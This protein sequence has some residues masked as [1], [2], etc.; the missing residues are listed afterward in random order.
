M[1][2][3]R[4]STG[5]GIGIVTNLND[6][7]QQ[8]RI[9][10]EFPWLGDSV[11]SHWCRLSTQ[12]GGFSRGNF[13][14]PEVGDEV[15]VM[16][17][18]GDITQP[19][20]VGCLWNGSDAPPGPG[21]GD[22]KNDFK[23]FESRSDHQMIFNDGDDGGY[24]EFHDCKKKLH[25]KIDVPGQ[26]IHSLAD[27]GEISINAPNGLVRFEC[28]DF[29]VH[30]TETT[31]VNVANSHG[32]NVTGS[33]ST[34]VK[35]QNL[36]QKAGKSLSV[37]TPNMSMSASSAVETS[38]GGTNIEIGSTNAE[39]KPTLAVEQSG[40][41]TRKIGSATFKITDVGTDLAGGDLGAGRSGPLTL[42]AGSLG[43]QLKEAFVTKVGGSSDIKFGNITMKGGTVAMAKDGGDGQQIGKAQMVQFEGGLVNLNPAMFTGPVTKMADLMLGFDVHSA[44]PMPFAFVLPIILD[45]KETVLVN[46]FTMAGAGTAAVGVHI[47]VVW[48]PPPSPPFFVPVPMPTRQI[49]AAAVMAMFMPMVMSVGMMGVS[50]IQQAAQGGN[51]TGILTGMD[52]QQ[53]RVRLMPYTESVGAFLATLVGLLPFPAASGS[54]TLAAPS[55]LGQ[56][57][58]MGF[59]MPMPFAN[60]CSEIPIIPNAT[61]I[62][63]STVMAGASM[64]QVAAQMAMQVAA[65]GLTRAMARTRIMRRIADPVDVMSGARVDEDVDVELPG[66]MPLKLVRN[67]LSTGVSIKDGGVLGYGN[68]LTFERRLTL[69]TPDGAPRTWTYHTDELRSIPLPCPMD[70]GEW[71]FIKAEQLEICRADDRL[72]D[73]RDEHGIT[74]RFHRWDDRACRLESWF[75]R[76]G[77]TCTVHYDDPD[78]TRATA[79]TDSTGRRLRLD[80]A[81]FG[82]GA[83]QTHRLTDIWFEDQSGDWKPHRLRMYRYDDAGQL[84]ATAGADDHLTRYVY[85]EHGRVTRRHEPNGYIWHWAYDRMD[86]VTHA[87]GEDLRYYYEFDYQPGASMTI[88]K[89][90]TGRKTL[91]GYDE[92]SVIN[93]VIDGEGVLRDAK[94][95]DNCLVE[96]KTGEELVTTHSYDDRGR[97]V[98]T[99]KPN[100]G[101]TTRVYD[102]THGQVI[103]EVSPMGAET[104]TTL[105]RQ[106]NPIR[107]KHPDGGE[108]MRRF[109]AQGRVVAELRPDQSEHLFTYDDAGN[110][111]E[112]SHDGVVQ[113]HIYDPLGRRRMTDAGGGQ[114]TRFEYDRAGR[115]TAV[116]YPDGT[117]E[118][119]VYDAEG[120]CI[121]HTA[122]TGETWRYTY[123]GAGRKVKTVTPEGQVHT[124][125]FGMNDM[126]SGHSDGANQGFRY[127]Y[128]AADR[129]STHETTDGVSERY[130]YDRHGQLVRI[131]HSDGSFVRITPA[132]H[133]GPSELT[134]RDGTRQTRVYNEDEFI[135][136]ALEYAPGA[137]RRHI[138]HPDK[139]VSGETRVVFK[140]HPDG[141]VLEEIGPHGR[142]RYT[143]GAQH[144][145]TRYNVDGV[146]LKIQR[147][148]KGR[149]VSVQAPDGTTYD[150]EYKGTARVIK[151]STGVTT[152][153]SPNSWVLRNEK[154]R[155]LASCIGA[156]DDFGRV[157]KETFRYPGHMG[158]VHSHRYNK[159]SRLDERYDEGGNRLLAGFRYGAG[160]QLVAT[161]DGAVRHD[162]RGRIV[163]RLSHDGEHRYR[164]DDFGR[165]IEAETPDGTVVHYRYDAM[166]RLVERIEDPIEGYPSTWRFMW[167][168]DF[169]A[170]EIRP[171]GTTIRYL[172]L[173]PDELVPWAA[174]VSG[175]D[176]A[177]GELHLLQADSRGA[178]QAAM[179]PDGTL[180]WWAE[181][182]PYGEAQVQDRGLDLRLRLAGMWSDPLTGIDFNRHRWYV[183]EWGRYLSPD[184]A[185]SKGGINR[186]AYAGGDPIGRIDPLGLS[187]TPN[188]AGTEDSNNNVQSRNNGADADAPPTRQPTAGDADAPPT[189]PVNAGDD[190]AP[191]NR[192]N[193]V[194]ALDG[195]QQRMD[196]DPANQRDYGPAH[197][198]LNNRLNEADAAA[199]DPE[200]RPLVEDD[201]QQIAS[202]ANDHNS[203]MDRRAPQNNDA[204]PPVE[205][206]P[207]VRENRVPKDNETVLGDN[208]TYQRT[209]LRN[210]GATVYRDNDGNYYHR[211][212]LHTGNG[213]EIETYNSQGQHTGTINP[214]GT[215]KDGPIK[216]RTLPGV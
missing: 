69:D 166:H 11:S 116:H 27:T 176:P 111:V 48:P 49:L 151:H 210:K 5:A 143:R 83:S 63:V 191:S 56:D 156:A 19:W 7:E 100:G 64:K 115:Q 190:G 60:T 77:N 3:D 180:T 138:F 65:Y 200:L 163:S 12:Q 97:R 165:L 212:T 14:R 29:N 62:S 39:I 18:M 40:P 37:T 215:P 41:V 205:Q 169:M 131:D 58:P 128:D 152:W 204:A 194:N 185:G 207:Y 154:Q 208:S 59:T 214:D 101:K 112:E 80:Y 1:S 66:P 34:T 181:Y 93:R 149:A 94:Y 216:G 98:E 16:F 8:G 159:D 85:D 137:S 96:E 88:V 153:R 13:I 84:V 17:E 4:F 104:R 89:D 144:K 72:W 31:T 197:N 206:P 172:R 91:Y 127:R 126:F 70:F 183:P 142:M 157:S 82:K 174:W 26:H 122:Y 42:N 140:R 160:H 67:H 35:K 51:P 139:P 106:G 158:Y 50:M 132:P 78:P 209:N 199:T 86:R 184:P 108:T 150:I 10:V 168:G 46:G 30:S 133:G 141:T 147:D 196:A 76:H 32:I 20:V 177:K 148:P 57:M 125:A 171:D 43:M 90:H 25:T 188:R 202:E 119:K 121:E 73:V 109:D 162:R 195:M 155:T 173:D 201:Y 68:R 102:D 75:D 99:I 124:H 203:A 129:L 113:K 186:Y 182:T 170:G 47:P 130:S 15:L 192:D 79:L 38:T 136:E 117:S 61:V 33:R 120:R 6:P 161:P 23:F 164:W 105:D 53:W 198:D 95:E 145:I 123:D 92:N 118:S 146:S 179:R 24:I 103:L 71:H 45:T 54:I 107:V 21:N 52:A 44:P 211:D 81:R 2:N 36:S 74:W 87:Y 187:H 22:G 167:S 55:V 110:L 114:I 193:A 134:A 28:V 175:E 9:L 178:A 213:A 189:R 135:V